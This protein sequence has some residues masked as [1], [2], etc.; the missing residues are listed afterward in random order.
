[1]FA[2]VYDIGVVGLETPLRDTDL[3]TSTGEGERERGWKRR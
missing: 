1:M 2:A 3:Q